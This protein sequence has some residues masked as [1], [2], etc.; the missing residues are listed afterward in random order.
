MQ[1]LVKLI[2]EDDSDEY[3]ESSTSLTIILLAILEDDLSVRIFPYDY[4][5]PSNIP[6]EKELK[7]SIIGPLFTMFRALAEASEDDQS[8]RNSLMT[9]VA[10][11]GTNNSKVG[12]LLIYFLVVANFM[13]PRMSIYRHY[14][15]E[16]N[17]ELGDSLLSDLKCCAYDDVY[18]FF[19]LLPEIFLNLN[20]SLIGTTT[21]LIK[22][23]VSHADSVQ[24]QS[25]LCRI[26]NGSIKLVRKDGALSLIS[27]N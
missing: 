2:L 13:A 1:K 15:R 10:A 3:E 8:N 17:K 20:S 25:I 14:A 4:T 24:L 26:I 12:Y 18:M 5:K 9:L 11:M 23:I 27:M 6:D 19:Y 16:M 22:L 7:E 21:D